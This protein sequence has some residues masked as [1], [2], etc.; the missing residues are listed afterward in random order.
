MDEGY[1]LDDLKK[2]YEEIKEKHDLP[3]F[4][5]LNKDFSIDQLTEHETD[6]LLRE[7]RRAIADKISTYMRFVETILNPVNAPIFVFSLIKTINSEEKT[8]LS[9]VY[10]KLAKFEVRIIE[11]DVDFSEK[12][13]ADFVKEAY[14]EWQEMKK[15]LLD[16]VEVIKKNWDNKFE[17]GARGYF[18]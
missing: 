10:K 13:E 18:G 8:K 4:E 9:E 11:L 7:I 12:K 5:E 15:D 2:D 16:V 3:S 14:E 1:G 17:S 6:Y